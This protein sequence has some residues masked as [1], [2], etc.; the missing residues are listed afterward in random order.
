MENTIAEVFEPQYLVAIG[1]LLT[2]MI[3]DKYIFA[4][5]STES[6]YAKIW[7]VATRGLI[8]DPSL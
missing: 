5:I 2:V 1:S 3:S 6:N 8:T 4:R 7:G